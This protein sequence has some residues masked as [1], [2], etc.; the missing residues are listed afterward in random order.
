MKIEIVTPADRTEAFK[1]EIAALLATKEVKKALPWTK[2]EAT[3]T[4]IVARE[5]EQIIAFAGIRSIPRGHE[6]CSLYVSP[7]NRQQGVAGMLIAQ[8]LKLVEN[9]RLVRV[10]CNDQSLQPYL[11]RGF[12]PVAK[13]GS[14]T[15]V[16]RRAA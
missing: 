14:Y 1:A 10:V 11:R 16:E 2:D 13:R 7:A 6:L 8:R 3:K 4:W 12:K 5:G 15:V 9:D